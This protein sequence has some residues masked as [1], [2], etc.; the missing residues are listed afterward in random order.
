MYWNRDPRYRAGGFWKC[1]E[2]GRSYARVRYQT[3]EA[4]AAASRLRAA[5]SENRRLDEEPLFA[6]KKLLRTRR[7]KALARAARRPPTNPKVALAL[8]AV[9]RREH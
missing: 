7:S 8:R 3:D 2:H 1:A 6:A 9:K 5:R 4:Y